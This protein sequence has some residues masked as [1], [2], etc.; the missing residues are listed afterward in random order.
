MIFRRAIAVNW[1]HIHAKRRKL[2][3][4]SNNKENQSR[5]PWN[6]APGDQVLIILYA[7]ER[8]GQTMKQCVTKPTFETPS[9][10]GD[11]DM[12]YIL[13]HAPLVNPF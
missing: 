10:M 12:Q 11:N 2:L 1:E 9:F 5:L 13:G 4:A 3:Q 7:Y 8:R 6:Y